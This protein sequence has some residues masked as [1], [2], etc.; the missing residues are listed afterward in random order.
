MFENTYAGDSLNCREQAVTSLAAPFTCDD[1]ADIQAKV[2][3]LG[4][5]VDR[6][7]PTAFLDAVRRRGGWVSLDVQGF[8]RTA[9]NGRIR[10][11]EWGEKRA[12]LACV[13]MVKADLEEARLLSGEP[14]PAEAA[15]R[16]AELGPKEV[17][18][19]LGSGGSLILDGDRLHRIPAFRPRQCA[20]A[21]GCGDSYIAGYIFYRLKSDD[22]VAAGR[23]AAALA[24]L[25]LECFG[26]FRGSECDVYAVLAEAESARPWADSRDE[27]GSRHDAFVD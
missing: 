16:I 14:D 18:V 23:F 25:K 15:R 21:T 1:L 24:A 5:L 4:P 12:G 7:M 11:R 8:M 27:G 6:D 3:H 13:D 17:I 2:F 10:A 19:T 20:D 9:V 22:I 26:P